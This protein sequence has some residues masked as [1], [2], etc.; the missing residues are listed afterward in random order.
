MKQ[1]MIVIL[2]LGSE[3]NP[4]LAREIRALGVYSEIH[5]H[6]I[7]AEELQ[8]LDNVK[9]VILNGGEN[10]VVDGKAVEIRPELYDL[11]IPDGYPGRSMRLSRIGPGI[12]PPLRLLGAISD[13]LSTGS[14][15]CPE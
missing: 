14:R 5:P 4:R 6:D 2:D 3:E 12:V 13:V 15:G 8:A 10:R 9:G 7:T 1:D 11:D